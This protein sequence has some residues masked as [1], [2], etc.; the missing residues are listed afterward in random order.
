MVVVGNFFF[1]PWESKWLFLQ[2]LCGIR[3]LNLADLRYGSLPIF[4]FFSYINK[5]QFRTC[6]WFEFSPQIE[7]S[8]KSFSDGRTKLLWFWTTCVNGGLAGLGIRSF[9]LAAHWKRA[10]N[11]NKYC[12]AMGANRFRRSLLKE[13][14]APV[15]LYK[16]NDL[17]PSLFLK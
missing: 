8:G 6:L 9:A 5:V 17:L 15:A 7:N 13:W 4:D 14:F 3:C 1:I 10:T 12:R 2:P 11:K 16:K